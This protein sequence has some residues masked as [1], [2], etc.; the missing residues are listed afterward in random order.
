M[1]ILSDAPLAIN[2]M[3]IKDI[4]VLRTIKGGETVYSAK[5]RP[6]ITVA[7]FVPVNGGRTKNRFGSIGTW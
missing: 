7:E 4:R 5:S 3:A 1:V 6:P 2:P